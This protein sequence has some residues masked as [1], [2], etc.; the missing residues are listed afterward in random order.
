MIQGKGWP[1]STSAFFPSSHENGSSL[2]RSFPHLISFHYSDWWTHA[3][4][5][6]SAF[7][8][9]VASQ[10]VNGRVP[11]LCSVRTFHCLLPKRLGS[12]VAVGILVSQTTS[13]TPS[14]D[15]LQLPATLHRH[16][17]SQP[18]LALVDSGTQENFLDLAWQYVIPLEPLNPPFQW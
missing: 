15:K 6:Y 17:T 13:S 14:S 1:L 18:L 10:N 2:S 11:V 5:P 3:V 16:Q 9:Q 7:P 4:R 12:P 8:S